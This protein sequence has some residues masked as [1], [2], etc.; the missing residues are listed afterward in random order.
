MCILLYDYSWPRADGNPH[1]R[2]HD[3]ALQVHGVGGDRVDTSVSAGIHHRTTAE[4]HARVS[5]HLLSIS[6]FLDALKL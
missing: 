6:D 4:L 1:W 5:G 2:L 3:E